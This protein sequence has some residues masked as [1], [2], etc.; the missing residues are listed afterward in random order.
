[1]HNRTWL[2]AV[3]FFMMAAC[4]N[5]RSGSGRRSSGAEEQPAGTKEA[6][7]EKQP[8]PATDNSKADY[9]IYIENS[10]SMF[11]YVTRPTTFTNSV[12]EI[13]TDLYAKNVANRLNLY[14]I[15]DSICP[16]KPNADPKD[17]QNFIRNLSPQTM[18]NSGC[19]VTDSQLPDI[20]KQVIGAAPDKVNILISDCIFSS[21]GGNSAASLDAAKNSLELFVS[22]EL[23][24]RDFSTIL[25]KLT[26]PYYGKY[27]IESANRT[28][29]WEWLNGQSRP[30]YMLVFGRQDKLA[31]FYSHIR[32][33]EYSGYENS[34]FMLPP[35]ASHPPAQIIRNNKIGDFR[36][37]Q[38]ATR[39]VINNAV[40]GGRNA[41]SEEFQF[42]LAAD[43]T[44]LS[45]EEAYLSNPGNYELPSN[46][47]L[48][49]VA[50]TDPLNNESQAG[51]SHIFTL[52]TIDLKQNQ[53]VA[54]KL[55][56]K[57]PDWI[58]RSSNTDDS[59][60][61]DAVQQKQTFGLEY[62]VRGMSEA[63][64]DKYEGKEQLAINVQVSKDNYAAHGKSGGFPWA[65]IISLIVIVFIIVWLKNKK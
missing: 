35:S 40:P 51:Y 47:S 46:Y 32:F 16:Q 63:Y 20:I 24:K 8:L 57:M 34:H 54:I 59:R 33:R 27:W 11:G 19:G 14:F 25:I 58:S 5:N 36:I 62:L 49:S 21:N 23:G 28:K 10:G 37:E 44:N 13:I 2:L 64:A 38:P 61:F 3:F 55:K 53:E 41:A 30:Y 1:M 39:L 48:V 18:S 9:N 50:K 26:S 15:N 52:K 12:Y 45:M 6:P 22:R 60:P 65:I 42:S 4:N 29:K 7:A 43:L 31:S 56:S 17:M